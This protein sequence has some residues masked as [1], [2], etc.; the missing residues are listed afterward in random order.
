MDRNI[1]QTIDAARRFLAD[2]LDTDPDTPAAELLQQNTI[3]RILIVELL[4]IV[5]TDP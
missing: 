2:N 4:D 3:A 5:V 1:T